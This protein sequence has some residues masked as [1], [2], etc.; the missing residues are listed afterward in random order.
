[1]DIRVCWIPSHKGIYGNDMADRAAKSAI[2]SRSAP[3][4]KIPHSDFY[5]VAA[6]NLSNKIEELCSPSSVT[7]GL[8]YFDK[9]YFKAVKPWFHGLAINREAIVN[10][11]RIRSNHYNL[12]A[13]LFR[14][15]MVP[16]PYCPCGE[17]IQDINHIVFY[18]P[19]TIHKSTYLRSFLKEK[20]PHSPIN[21]FD[22]IKY[23]CGKLCRL[24]TSYLK[25]CD[26]TV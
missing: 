12:R 18:C 21:V 19:N 7:K 3:L 24:V 1:M 4:F 15:N 8:V 2:V 14:K 9:C 6:E 25:S 10:M 20:F 5:A 26:L 16:D 17:G 13:S 11:S 22:I 23:P